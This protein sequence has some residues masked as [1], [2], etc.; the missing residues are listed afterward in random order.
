MHSSTLQWATTL[1]WANFSWRIAIGVIALLLLGS[2]VHAHPSVDNAMEVVVSRD[3]VVLRPRISLVEIDIAHSVG[4]ARGA[5]DA[6]KLNAAIRTHGDYLLSHMIISAD[7][8]SLTGTVKAITPPT[9]EV[10]WEDFE[11]KEAAY[12]IEYPLASPPKMV[13]IEE[14]LLK[15]FS[16]LG[17]PWAVMFV[18][19]HRLDSDEPFSQSLL[20]RD[21]ALEIT[22][23]WT[24][25]DRRAATSTPANA[26][27]TRLDVWRVA[28][29]YTW[30]GL[31]HILTGY[32]HLLFVA[33]LVIGAGRLWDL[34]KVVTAF[35]IAHTL[36][37]TLAVLGV[38]RLSS[39]IVEPMIAASIVFVALQNVLFPKQARGPTR[40]VVAFGFGL[41]HGLGFAG[42]LME[43]MKGMPAINLAAALLAFTIG[44]ELAHQLLIVP[45]FLFLQ[46]IRRRGGAPADAPSPGRFALPAPLR[47]ASMAISV[48]GIFYL[49]EALRGA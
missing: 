46:Q 1:R 12:E 6:A 27:A 45:L 16:R 21:Q 47:L 39:S 25:S 17:Q 24:S 7:G 2:Q 31:M 43:A 30:H 42:G 41:F 29:Q 40:L 34:V 49:V 35:A 10:K 44:V 3:R 23:H 19:K 5:V 13:R 37:L 33:A 32:D 18:V 15:E 36:T 22:C 20:S 9:G 48:A 11:D 8:H 26:N 14:D 38:V 4:D 28:R